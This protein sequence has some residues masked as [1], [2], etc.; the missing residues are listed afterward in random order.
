MRFNII[1]NL[2]SNR[3]LP[4]QNN[5]GITHPLA[6]PSNKRAVRILLECIL[7]TV[8]KRSLRTLCFYTRLSFCPLG[9]GVGGWESSRPTPKGRLGRSGWGWGGGLQSHT[10]GG[11]WEVWPGG[12]IQAHTGGGEVEGSGWGGLQTQAQ[13]GLQT[14]ACRG[15]GLCI[16]ACTEADT[17]SRRLLLR[18]VRILLECIL[19]VKC[20]RDITKRRKFRQRKNWT[21]GEQWTVEYRCK[22]QISASCTIAS[23]ALYGYASR[24]F[25][26]ITDRKGR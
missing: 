25:L 17:P 6:D 8:C 7:V 21:D 3:D 1:L 26:I 4:G 5:I 16:P 20:H 11:G 9:V 24:K 15:G 13:G 12:G 22:M 23:L 10:Q 14:Q 19:V 2:V 18:T